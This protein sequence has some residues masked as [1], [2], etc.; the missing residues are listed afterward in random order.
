VLENTGYGKLG[1]QDASAFVFMR[2]LREAMFFTIAYGPLIGT[3]GLKYRIA[4]VRFIYAVA[5]ASCLLSTPGCF[6]VLF[7]AADAVWLEPPA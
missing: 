3:L 7:G 4:T 6:K 1:A 2:G 5:P